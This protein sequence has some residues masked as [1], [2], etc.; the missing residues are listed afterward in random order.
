MSLAEA[1]HGALAP[2]SKAPLPFERLL[3]ALDAARLLLALQ[4]LGWSPDWSPPVAHAHD[5]EAEAVFLAE[6]S[7]L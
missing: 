4:W 3:E 6:K 1:Y 2:T 7:G 5:W